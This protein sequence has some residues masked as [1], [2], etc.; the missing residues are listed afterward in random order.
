MK[1]LELKLLLVCALTLLFSG[2][3]VDVGV[4]PALA[5]DYCSSAQV[6]GNVTNLAFDTTEATFDGPG[7]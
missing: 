3:Q 5:N 1:R 2:T 6:I 7:Y 4:L